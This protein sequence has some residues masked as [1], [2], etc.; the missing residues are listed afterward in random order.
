MNKAYFFTEKSGDYGGVYVAAKT[1][2]EARNIAISDKLISDHVD[3]P[4]IEV[5]GHL[6]RKNK[7]PIKTEI[8]GILSMQQI[9]DLGLAWWECEKCGY[10]NFEI[11]DCDQNFKC[12]DCGFIDNVPY[13]S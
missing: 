11:I 4:I 3:N 12:K 7:Q 6:C 9:C 8:E 13:V 10:S 2:K 1:W 5:E